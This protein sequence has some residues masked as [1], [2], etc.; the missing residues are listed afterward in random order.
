MTTSYRH[1]NS[2]KGSFARALRYVQ[3]A[4]AT[5]RGDGGAASRMASGACSIGRL[6]HGNG[7]LTTPRFDLARLRRWKRSTSL[8][9]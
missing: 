5:A 2:K 4:L 7:T 6:G 9:D 1:T 3:R 8:L